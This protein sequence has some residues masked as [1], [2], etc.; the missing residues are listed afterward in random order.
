MY[1]GACRG[2]RV[3][4]VAAKHA[5]AV[6]GERGHKGAAKIVVHLPKLLGTSLEWCL[7]A[8]VNHL[9]GEPPLLLLLFVLQHLRLQQSTHATESSTRGLC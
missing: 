4:W 8:R 6:L 5:A 2:R 7:C 9:K 3:L 1:A